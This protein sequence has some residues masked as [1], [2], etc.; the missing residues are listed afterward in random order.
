M[1][2][3]K[4]SNPTFRA[5]VYRGE[6]MHAAYGE[7]MTVEG[8]IHRTGILLLCV[9]ATA[10]YTWSRFLATH[11]PADVGLPVMVGVFGGFVMALVT[12]FKKEWSPVTAPIYALLE[13][14]FLGG[15]SAM[16]EVRFPGIA[17]QSVGL[18]FGTCFCMLAAYRSGLLRASPK[19]VVGVV[20]ATGGICLFYFLSMLLGFFGIGVPGVFGGGLV[21][22]LFSLVVVVI[23]SL[24]LILDFNFIEQGAEQG[25][26]KYMEWYGAFGLMVTLVWLYLEILRL[27][28]KLRGRR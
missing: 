3:M 21:G 23:A 9:L 5:S 16:A 1:E 17:I 11:D 6:N 15:V 22:I 13:G 27:L 8:T 18:T 26:P 2:I 25:A 28:S 12:C 14:L 7:T 19:F 20:A 4:T 24:N 10:L